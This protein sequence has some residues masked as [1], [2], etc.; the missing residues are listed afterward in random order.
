MFESNELVCGRCG[1]T[2]PATEFDKKGKHGPLKKFCRECCTELSRESE[3]NARRIRAERANHFGGSRMAQGG[4]TYAG[5]NVWLRLIGFNDY[6]EYLASD[7][8]KR[9]RA[10][11]FAV[12]GRACYLCGNTATQVHHMR[13]NKRGLL[14]EKIR[15]LHPICGNCHER[16]EFTEGKKATIIEAQKTFKTR[17]KRHRNSPSF[18]SAG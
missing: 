14:G 4:H 9:I 2:L 18:S 10:K 6:R 16:I 5:R 1:K 15:H 13:Y 17:R 12:K 7:L 3:K 11:V 8:W